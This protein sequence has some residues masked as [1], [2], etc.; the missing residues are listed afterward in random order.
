MSVGAWNVHR[1]SARMSQHRGAA[2]KLCIA[3]LRA[4]TASDRHYGMTYQASRY[5]HSSLRHC[6]AILPTPTPCCHPVQLQ[7]VYQDADKSRAVEESVAAQDLK[8]AL[9]AQYGAALDADKVCGNCC[10]WVGRWL[11]RLGGASALLCSSSH[12]QPAQYTGCTVL[13]TVHPG[14]LRCSPTWGQDMHTV[15]T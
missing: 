2:T 5:Q 3:G 13:Y 15:C 12:V 14:V 9:T 11:G 6:G 8:T 1:M 4:S 10:A 7:C